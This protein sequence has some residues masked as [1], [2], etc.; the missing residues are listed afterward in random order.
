MAVALVKFEQRPAPSRRCALANVLRR[1]VTSYDYGI[2][3]KWL[4]LL[5]EIAPSTKT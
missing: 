5:K 3:A 2:G 1:A 4:E